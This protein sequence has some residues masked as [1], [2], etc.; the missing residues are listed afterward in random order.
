MTSG[1]VYLWITCVGPRH[2]D[3]RAL[4]GSS[5]REIKAEVKTYASG[6]SFIEVELGARGHLSLMPVV[7]SSEP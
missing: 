4:E 7:W 6:P 1:P 5:Q 3:N 2:E